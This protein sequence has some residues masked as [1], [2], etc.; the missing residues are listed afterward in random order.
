MQGRRRYAARRRCARLLLAGTELGNNVDP[1]YTA[2]AASPWLALSP[3]HTAWV[4]AFAALAHLDRT[5]LL[6]IEEP[7][8]GLHPSRI[9][10][11][12]K[13]L[14]EIA[15]TTQVIMA[16]HSPLVVH[17]LSADE[18]TLVTRSSADGTR[19]TLLRDLPKFDAR[20]KSCVLSS[21]WG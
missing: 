17:E 15:S 19:A 11:V 6:L 20:S 7:E 8:S 16:T 18:V 3:V 13:T 14:R 10:E 21:L 9:P 2:L 1:R 5:E 12:M 4:L